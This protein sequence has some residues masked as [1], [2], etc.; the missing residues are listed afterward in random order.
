ML[1]SLE[2]EGAA[3]GHGYPMYGEE[4][5]D[6]LKHLIEHFDEEAVPDYGRYVKEPARANKNGVQYIP[7]KVINPRILAGFMIAGAVTTFSL[8]WGI[9]KNM[10]AR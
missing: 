2:P 5:R 9:R 8:I 10:Q 3:T 6:S 1:A 7:R 4:L